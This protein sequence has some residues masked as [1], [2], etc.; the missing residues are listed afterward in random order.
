MRYVPD[1]DLFVLYLQAS[2]NKTDLECAGDEEVR[3]GEDF[4]EEGEHLVQC[5]FLRKV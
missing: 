1:L 2:K 5:P 3:A 4:R